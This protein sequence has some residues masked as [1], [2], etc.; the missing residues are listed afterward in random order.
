MGC[1]SGLGVVLWRSFALLFV[2]PAGQVRLG[3]AVLFMLSC[4]VVPAVLVPVLLVGLADILFDLRGLT[5]GPERLGGGFMGLTRRRALIWAGL[6]CA[7]LMVWSGAVAATAFATARGSNVDHF[8]TPT[9]ILP[10]IQ[11][12]PWETTRSVCAAR[13]LRPCRAEEVACNP[14]RCWSELRRPSVTK[15]LICYPDKVGLGRRFSEVGGWLPNWLRLPYGTLPRQFSLPGGVRA[16]QVFTKH[17]LL[18]Y[19]CA[20]DSEEKKAP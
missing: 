14:D 8:P 12:D 15:T 13:N 10:S 9:S 6:S 20:K 19:C 16:E 3:W 7:P 17:R 11:G 4:F 18:I 5:S 2:K 1:F